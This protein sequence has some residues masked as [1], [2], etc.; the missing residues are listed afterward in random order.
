LDLVRLQRPGFVWR[1]RPRIYLSSLTQSAKS[2]RSRTTACPA[3][4]DA[5]HGGEA[6][7]RHLGIEVG[8]AL[9]IAE[10]TEV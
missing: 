5:K 6:A 3:A 4:G 7:V 2:S 9:E 10:Q 8:D 1:E